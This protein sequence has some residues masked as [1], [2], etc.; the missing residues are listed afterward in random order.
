MEPYNIA[1]ATDSQLSIVSLGL[2][3]KEF[4]DEN[5]RDIEAK[6]EEAVVER[7]SG[8]T[9]KATITPM[10]GRWVRLVVTD[11]SDVVEDQKQSDFDREFQV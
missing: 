4:S 10:E 8:I 9:C 5:L 6:V 1:T 11:T 3:H 2:A 7:V